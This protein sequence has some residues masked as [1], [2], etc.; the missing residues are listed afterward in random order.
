MTGK[1]SPL[2]V[3]LTIVAVVIYFTIKGSIGSRNRDVR[4]VMPVRFWVWRFFTGKMMDGS[5][6]TNG[7]FRYRG[8]KVSGNIVKAT[9]WQ[10]RAGWERLV[11]RLTA[12]S[13]LTIYPFAYIFNMD[14]TF[15]VMTPLA[16]VFVGIYIFKLIR[17][18]VRFHINRKWIEPLH[19]AIYKE[20]GR[21][22]DEKGESYIRLPF[23]FREDTESEGLIDLPEKYNDTSENRRMSLATVIGMKLGLTDVE[24]A[25]HVESRN[26][27]LT[28]Y[29]SPPPPTEVLFADVQDLITGCLPGQALLGKGSRNKPIYIH[30]NEKSPHVLMSARTG[31][32]KSELL[33][34][35]LAQYLARGYGAIICDLKR[36]SH[37]WAK[38]LPNVVYCTTEEE[39]HRALIAAEAEVAQ[40]YDMIEQSG[41]IHTDVGQGVIVVVDE[42]NATMEALEQYWKNIKTPQSDRKSP[43]VIALNRLSFMG[44]AA[45]IHLFVLGNYG[46]VKSVGSSATRENFAIRILAQHTQNAWRMLIPEHWP[47]PKSGKDPGRVYLAHG[48]EVTEVQV[49]LISDDEAHTLAMSSTPSEVLPLTNEH[50]PVQD[51]AE[52]D[53]LA[54]LREACEWEWIPIKYDNARKRKS[55]EKRFPKGIVNE[56]GVTVYS[57]Q[58]LEDWYYNRQTTK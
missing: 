24:V 44:R 43:A 54:T 57:R 26:P 2:Y 11:I 23:K 3:L 21:R 19:H 51:T 52:I 20:I 17:A 12:F 41:S 32:G 5:H 45:K 29:R 13:Y 39:I 25:F 4:R 48:L 53:M 42:M 49:V 1:I 33:K 30:V 18:A 35:V 7:T 56:T 31:A 36:I 9:N 46:T 8:D 47:P 50:S 16:A 40:R 58:E 55:R 6:P 27:Y 38:G 34:T 14:R 37:M 15:G 22:P 10:Y 28:F